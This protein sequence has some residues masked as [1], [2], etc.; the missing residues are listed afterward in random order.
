MLAITVAITPSSGSAQ[1][2]DS[3]M[4]AA[5]SAA[6]V[7]LVDRYHDA[8]ARGDS[9]LALSLLAADALVLESGALETLEEYRSHHLPGD[10]AFARAV[11]R[12]RG[13]I[14]VVIR[15]DVAWASTITTTEGEYRSRQVSSTGAELAVLSRELDG[16]KIRAIHWSSRARR[17]SP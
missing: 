8:L 1:S 15:G 11:R 13:P 16:W 10:I 7:A 6:V 12:E 17:P 14:R 5:D 3:S 4:R 2:H 9:A